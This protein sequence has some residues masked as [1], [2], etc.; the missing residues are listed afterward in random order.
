M[1]HKDFIISAMLSVWKVCSASEIGQ[2]GLFAGASLL[3]GAAIVVGIAA[4]ES[5]HDTPFHRPGASRGIL[6]LGALRDLLPEIRTV[7]EA[8]M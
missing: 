1:I 7:T 3:G 8:T 6:E 4:T 2:G 5:T